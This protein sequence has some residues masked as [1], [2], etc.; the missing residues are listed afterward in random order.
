ML[1][2]EQP[3]DYVVATGETHSVREF[4]EKAFKEVGIKVVW[5]GTGVEEVGKDKETGKILVQIDPRY[6]RPTEADFLQGDYTKART[7]LG[8]EPKVLFD[9]LVKIMVREDLKKAEKDRFCQTAGF[10][11]LNQNE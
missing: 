11:M 5:E 4:V 3:E 6:F 7:K 8:W 9:E 1:Q 10:R 2:Q